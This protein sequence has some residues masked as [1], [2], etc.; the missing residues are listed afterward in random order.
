MIATLRHLAS[1]PGI[2]YEPE[3]D[4]Q[5][6]SFLEREFFERL[7]AAGIQAPTLQGIHREKPRRTSVRAVSA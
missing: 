2:D 6:A 3:P 5:L 4:E 1:A 7:D